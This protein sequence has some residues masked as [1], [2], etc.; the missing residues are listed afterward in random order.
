MIVDTSDIDAIIIID[1]KQLPSINPGQTND[2]INKYH[3]VY[4]T[5]LMTKWTTYLNR[6]NYVTK[7]RCRMPVLIVELYLDN[8]KMKLDLQ[9]T[10]DVIELKGK[11]VVIIVD[12]GKGDQ[13]GY[14]SF[15]Q[16][17]WHLHQ[18]RIELKN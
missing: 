2:V 8:F 15:E 3:S 13:D 12:T 17:M 14:I 6:W 7:V 1:Q 18:Y 9:F 10:S 16:T 5:R 11:R 4:L